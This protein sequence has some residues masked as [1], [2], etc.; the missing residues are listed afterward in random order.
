M[1]RMDWM[2]F[3]DKSEVERASILLSRSPEDFDRVLYENHQAIFREINIEEPDFELM[4]YF[5]QKSVV[6]GK[7]QQFRE[8]IALAGQQVEEDFEV[9]TSEE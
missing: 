7:V 2:P 8:R 1:A 3:S 6:E 5:R 4:A 9:E